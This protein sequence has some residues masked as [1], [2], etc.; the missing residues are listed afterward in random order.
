MGWV[1]RPSR[2][3][4]MSARP[5]A[6]SAPQ[7]PQPVPVVVDSGTGAAVKDKPAADVHLF[8]V[9]TTWADNGG[10]ATHLRQK[11]SNR[12]VKMSLEEYCTEE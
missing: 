8:D 10:D 2:C 6:L 11:F 3:V 12:G 1:R 9:T 7:S 4:Q 5:D